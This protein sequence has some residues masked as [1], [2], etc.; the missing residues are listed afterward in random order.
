MVVVIDKT[1]A[2][3]NIFECALHIKLSIEQQRSGV[4]LVPVESARFEA[5]GA[6]IVQLIT[7]GASFALGLLSDVLAGCSSDTEEDLRHADLIQCMTSEVL[8]ALSGYG[9]IIGVSVT[10][11]TD[12]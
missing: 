8:V 10:V 9:A 6:K 1:H 5:V 11:E 2:G 4:Q 3:L 7:D 12:E